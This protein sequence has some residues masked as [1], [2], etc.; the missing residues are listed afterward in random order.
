MFIFT[1]QCCQMRR[2]S[3]FPRWRRRGVLLLICSID[4]A[5]GNVWNTGLELSETE[6]EIPRYLKTFSS[7]NCHYAHVAVCKGELDCYGRSYVRLPVA[8]KASNRQQ[9][10]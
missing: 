6:S 8:S 10:S 9:R 7:D 4:L 3:V 2:A 5:A 1:C